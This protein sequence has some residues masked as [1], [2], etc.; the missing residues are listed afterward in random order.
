MALLAAYSVKKGGKS[1][2]EWLDGE[3]FKGMKKNIS[4]PEKS[5]AEG[6]NKFMKRYTSALGAQRLLGEVK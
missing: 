2:P 4:V 6:F 3:V 5:G 1:L